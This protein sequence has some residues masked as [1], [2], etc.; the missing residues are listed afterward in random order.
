MV[1]EHDLEEQLRA[2]A[3][4]VRM[5]VV[6]LLALPL[7]SRSDEQ[8]QGLCACDIESV[9][10]VGQSTVS[11]HMKLLARAGLITTEK[12]GRW[13]YYRLN[14]AAFAELSA[15]LARFAGDAAACVAAGDSPDAG[16]TG[17]ACCPPAVDPAGAAEDEADK[18]LRV[19]ARRRPS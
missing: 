4:P 10:G 8:G 15:A 14:Q 7:R 12:K 2:L 11:H 5:R 9:M 16:A 19:V 17:G 13:V 18:R 3:D 6:K 1:K